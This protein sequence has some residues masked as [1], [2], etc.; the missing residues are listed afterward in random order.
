MNIYDRRPYR[1]HNADDW[2]R[3]TAVWPITSRVPTIAHE[4]F[5]L[6][7][8]VWNIHI[9]ISWL[10]QSAYKKKGEKK[11]ICLLK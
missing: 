9:L 11:I 4:T 8:R 10:P 2:K 6:S 7:I 1:N 5:C 3:E